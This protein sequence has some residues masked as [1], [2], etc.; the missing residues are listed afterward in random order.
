MSK[1]TEELEAI[2]GKE[3]R[4]QCRTCLALK[5]LDH[6][7]A[8]ALDTARLAR[9]LTYEDMSKLLSKHT[10]LNMTSSSVRL[11][12]KKGHTL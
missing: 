3:V 9:Q 5:E 4:T 8:L 2:I 12:Y 6:E 1:V 7:D 11:H 10:A